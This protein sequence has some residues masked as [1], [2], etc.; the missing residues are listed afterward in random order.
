MTFLRKTGEKSMQI[1]PIIAVLTFTLMLGAGYANANSQTYVVCHI[2]P[3]NQNK[4]ETKVFDNEDAMKEHLNHGDLEGTCDDHAAVLCDDDNLCTLD[5]INP[6]TGK[7]DSSADVDCGDSIACTHDTCNPEI[8]C[9]HLVTCQNAEPV[10]DP[11][12]GMCKGGFGDC[13]I[14]LIAHQIFNWN[15]GDPVNMTCSSDPVATITS[16]AETRRA[17]AYD[18]NLSDDCILFD[19][20][21]GD[22]YSISD[23]VPRGLGRGA[24]LTVGGRP[25]SCAHLFTA[26]EAVESCHAGTCTVP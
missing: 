16:Y 25:N 24:Y 10:C 22:L 1:I 4:F 13:G 21:G 5:I 19:I 12:D 17:A 26:P 18:N 23:T 15:E 8:G 6:D 11:D 20:L 3:G 9:E 2:S 7:C 14:E